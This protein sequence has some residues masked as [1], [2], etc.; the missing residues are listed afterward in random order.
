MRSALEKLLPVM[1]ADEPVRTLSPAERRALAR[2]WDGIGYVLLPKQD[3]RNI[4]LDAVTV[5]QRRYLERRT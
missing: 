1:R 2:L 3:L 4:E 5:I